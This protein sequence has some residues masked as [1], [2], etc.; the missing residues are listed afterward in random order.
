MGERNV[1]FADNLF[2]KR[3]H[4]QGIYAIVKTMSCIETKGLLR[5][6]R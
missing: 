1:A 6:L 2:P 5:M 4:K 3:Q